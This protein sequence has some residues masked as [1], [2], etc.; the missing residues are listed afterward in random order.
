MLAAAISTGSIPA[1]SISRDERLGL[2]RRHVGDQQAVGAGFRGVAHEPGPRDDD[3]GIGED[4]D[5]HIR[6]ARAK[7]A[8]QLE[9]I[10]DPDAGG[11]R[12]LRRGLDHRPVG[13][14]IGERDP[15]LDH[16]GAA[17]DRARRE[18]RALVSRSGSPSIRKA[19]NAPSPFSRSNMAA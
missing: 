10:A 6:M 1:C 13:D 14:G 17:F 2:E 3:V 8:E 4:A 9:A 15:D 16:V 19:P 11:Q 12:A 7:A 5:G 18:A